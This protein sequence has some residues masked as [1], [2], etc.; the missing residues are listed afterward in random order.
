M[1][2]N[3]PHVHRITLG[4]TGGRIDYG[5]QHGYLHLMHETTPSYWPQWYLRWKTNRLITKLV[6]RHDK[7][8]RNESLFMVAVRIAVN[9]NNKLLGPEF[10]QNTKPTEQWGE[11]LLKEVHS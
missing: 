10:L 6:R 5:D 3:Q 8:S 11:V 1:A 4:S 7:A 9:H 2:N